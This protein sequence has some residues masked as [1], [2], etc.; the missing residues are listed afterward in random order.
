M[1]N[2]SKLEEMNGN[3]GKMTH[4]GMKERDVTVFFIY[5]EFSIKQLSCRKTVL[6]L[7]IPFLC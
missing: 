5:V 3:F 6:F 4:V 7:D 2:F 1:G